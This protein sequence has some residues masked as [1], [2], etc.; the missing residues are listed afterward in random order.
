MYGVRIWKTS[1]A[2]TNPAEAQTLR[3][4]GLNLIEPA[5][6]AFLV[7]GLV[8]LLRP[9]FWDYLMEADGPFRFSLGQALVV[10]LPVALLLLLPLIGWNS[11]D[12]RCR[13]INRRLVGLGLARWGVTAIVL[14]AP[15]FMFLGM[16]GLGFSLH[17]I[18][19]QAQ[20]PYQA[21]GLGPEGVM[22]GELHDFGISNQSNIRP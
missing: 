13:R 11:V 2:R 3:F 14:S 9:H 15:F 16:I 17:W 19:Q 21:V 4:L 6:N 12:Q 8:W 22:V 1:R 18:K 5:L 20:H 7:P 10:T